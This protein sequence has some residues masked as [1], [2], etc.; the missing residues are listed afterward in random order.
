NTVSLLPAPSAPSD[1]RLIEHD[2]EDL[3]VGLE[4]RQLGRPVA[5][6]NPGLRGARPQGGREPTAGHGLAV[7]ILD[8]H[9]DDARAWLRRVAGPDLLR[10]AVAL[11]VLL[12][13]LLVAVL[14]ELVE[15]DAL[16]QVDRLAAGLLDL[17]AVALLGVQLLER[18]LHERSVLVAVRGRERRAVA[19]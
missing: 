9:L 16:E 11:G 13:V 1:R 4:P 19:H 18:E 8:A 5:A 15:L 14:V 6:E 7:L 12:R 17:H 2:L 10:V 3:V